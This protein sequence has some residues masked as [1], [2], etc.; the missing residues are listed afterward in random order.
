MALVKDPE[1]M[2][3][4]V[5]DISQKIIGIILEEVV[6]MSKQEDG[7][8]ESIYFLTHVAANLKSRVCLS[9]AAFG[10]NFNIEKIS[11]ESISEVIDAIAQDI[12]NNNVDTIDDAINYVN[13]HMSSEKDAFI[14]TN[15]IVP[16][17]AFNLIMKDK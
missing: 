15:H 12:F 8:A 17:D 10:K 2:N 9:C 11:V 5:K 4:K 6:P 7:L 3:E 13:N 16:P 1:L 14:E